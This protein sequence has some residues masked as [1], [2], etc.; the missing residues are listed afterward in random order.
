MDFQKLLQNKTLLFSIIGGVVLLIIIFIII[1]FSRPQVGSNEKTID[2]DED[3]KIEGV[4]ELVTSDNL[5]KILEIEALL[6][7][8]KIQTK[9]LSSG[10]K[11]TLTLKDKST[12][13][14][15]D[16]ALLLI[17]ESGLADANV[18]LE[19]FDKGDFTSTKDD[20]KIRLAR[21]INGELS[22]LI[23]KIDP[24]ENASVFISIPDQQI[25]T[26]MQKPKTATVQLVMPVGEK[27]SKDKVRAI[28]NLLLGSVSGLEL[29]NIS[30]TDTNGNVY[31]SM[32]AANDGDL[33]KIEEND[34]YMKSKVQ[35][36][37]DKLLGKGNYVVTVST[38]LR[39][40]PMERSSVIYDPERNV[41]LNEQEFNENLGDKNNENGQVTNAVSLYL[42]SGLPQSANTSQ[43]RSYSRTASEKQ[44]G[45]TKTQVSEYLKPGMIEDISIAVTI[46]NNSI[47]EMISIDDL[48]QL[49]AT[50]A[51]PKVSAENVSIIFADAARPALAGDK[52]IKLPTPEGSGNPWW[53]MAVVLLILIFVGWF[54]LSKR[55]SLAAATQE[56]KIQ[57]L[58]NLA[59]QQENKLEEVNQ[60]AQIL[61]AQQDQLQQSLNTIRQAPPAVAATPQP[62]IP[63]TNQ[64]VEEIKQTV[65]DDEDE[66]ALQI[67]NWIESD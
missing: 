62:A 60:R 47:P 22:R 50:A 7:K 15:R 42:P 53:T 2:P 13:K 9:R 64:L 5:G 8:H 43:N 31:S 40:V 24:I 37:L 28:T 26:S 18:G 63:A 58:K 14:Q 67:K 35:A 32:A 49:I 56:E 11:V 48:K 29:N 6:A 65:E 34:E 10:S 66:V 61:L 45:S 16:Q 4:V 52:D 41:V 44:Y 27:L 30:I 25:F 33:E 17:V 1:G 55:V 12:L 20:K 19:V 3:K 59:N 38:Y 39:Q 23:R 46:E 21:A 57:T 51:S 36:Q 54:L